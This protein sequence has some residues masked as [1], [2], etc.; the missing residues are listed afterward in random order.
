MECLWYQ[1][2][3]MLIICTLLQTDN[4]PALR[5]SIF[6]GQMLFLKPNQQ[7]MKKYHQL[8]VPGKQLLQG[9][10][11]WKS[12]KSCRNLQNLLEIFWPSLCV[13]CMTL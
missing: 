13:S 1:L 7:A 5:R 9:V 10:Y 2:H 8:S 4:P 11:S 3:K 12:W 6:T